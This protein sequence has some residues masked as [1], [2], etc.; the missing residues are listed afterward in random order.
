MI[1]L[2]FKV[3]HISEPIRLSFK[4]FD[5]VV[6]SFDNGTGDGIFEIVEKPRFVAS[7]SFGYPGKRADSRLHS[8]LNPHFKEALCT[9]K[10]LIVPEESQLLFHGMSNE[11][12]VIGLKEGIE[13]GFAIRVKGVVVSQEQ[14]TIP[15]EGFL[16]EFVQ[17]SLLA[18][19]DFINGLVH[20][21]RDVVAVKDNINM[22]QPPTNSRIITSA[23]VHGDRIEFLCLLG[24]LFDEGLDL[25]FTPA[26]NGMQDSSIL[27][28]DKNGHVFMA[29]SQAELINSKVFDFMQ[30]NRPVEQ[31][32]PLFVDLF[33]KIPAHCEVLRDRTDGAKLQKIQSCECERPYITVFTI[34]KGQSG[35]PK[36]STPQAFESVEQKVQ[37]TPFPSN[38]T[39]TQK[40]SFLPF[41]TGLSICAFWAP[42]IL[43]RHSGIDVDAVSREM[44]GLIVDTFQTK[45]MVEYRCG[46]GLISPPVVRLQSNNWSSCHVHF[47]FSTSGTHFPEDPQVF[48]MVDI[49]QEY[50]DPGAVSRCGSDQPIERTVKVAT[51]IESGQVISQGLHLLSYPF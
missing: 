45:S 25:F 7:Q 13:S 31:R 18:S 11:K 34:H 28:I 16:S 33:D 47:L 42:H 37:E 24:E 35:P 9:V 8:I 48:K 51:I 19:S 43:I 27:D 4:G 1:E 17:L 21:S 10:L 44:A 23:H 2:Q 26:F 22:G 12:G 39:H 38:G 20:E 5:F 29:L 40:S 6:G 3:D 32:E 15:F 36:M 14:E 41:E 50:G 30:G 46:H 49:N